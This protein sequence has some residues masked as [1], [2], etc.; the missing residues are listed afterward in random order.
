VIL[1][2]VAGVPAE[3]WLLPFLSAGAALAGIRA[4]FGSYRRG[5]NERSRQ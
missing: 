3:E 1:A 4:T 2:R 5:Q